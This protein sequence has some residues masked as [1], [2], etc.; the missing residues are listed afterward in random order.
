MDE[1]MQIEIGCKLCFHDYGVLFI[2]LLLYMPPA[3]NAESMKDFKIPHIPQ[4]PWKVL[5]IEMGSSPWRL[6]HLRRAEEPFQVKEPPKFLQVLQD[7]K[8]NKFTG[9]FQK[10]G[11]NRQQQQQ[12]IW[13]SW[14]Q[15]KDALLI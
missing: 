6:C 10:W 5:H 8:L 15:S 14:R 7:P 3:K 4:G 13:M 1:S 11:Y 2:Y 9:E 12:Y